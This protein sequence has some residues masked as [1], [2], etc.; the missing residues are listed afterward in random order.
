MLQGTCRS[1]EN[2]LG[3]SEELEQSPN[4]SG[5]CQHTPQGL[6]SSISGGAARTPEAGEGA[7]SEEGE[8]IPAAVK[9]EE[10]LLIPG[11]G[12]MHQGQISSWRGRDHL[13]PV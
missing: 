7:E 4:P 10:M 6:S 2:A 3:N 12:K 8:E 13:A 5:K 9:N 11:H 1:P